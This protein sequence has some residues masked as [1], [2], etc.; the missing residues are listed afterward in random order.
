MRN[1]LLRQAGHCTIA[2]HQAK[3]GLK[4]F[5]GLKKFV[6]H[7]GLLKDCAEELNGFQ[8]HN[9]PNFYPVF[10]RRKHALIH[11]KLAFPCFTDTLPL[12]DVSR[13]QF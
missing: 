8:T 12:K 5:F 7:P 4:I 3:G 9:S 10:V 6:S 11:A 2:R 13:N 1:V